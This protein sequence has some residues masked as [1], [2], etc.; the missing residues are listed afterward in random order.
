MIARGLLLLMQIW[1]CTVLKYTY[2]DQSL[3][4]GMLRLKS[5]AEIKDKNLTQDLAARLRFGSTALL[6]I[7]HNNGSH[8]YY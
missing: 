8:F 3:S 1:T 7:A 5:R 6:I 2:V 4:I